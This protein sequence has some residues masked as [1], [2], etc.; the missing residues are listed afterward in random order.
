METD[1]LELLYEELDSH[2]RGRRLPDEPV[3]DF[4][5]RQHERND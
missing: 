2:S 5:R 4:F 1:L 3:G